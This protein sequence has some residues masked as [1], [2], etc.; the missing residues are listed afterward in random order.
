MEAIPAQRTPFVEVSAPGKLIISGEHSVVYGKNALCAALDLRCRCTGFTGGAPTGSI[1]FNL[2]N[3]SQSITVDIAALKEALLGKDDIE[4][5]SDFL[6]SLNMGGCE[7][8][9]YN[10]KILKAFRAARHRLQE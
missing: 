7:A 5:Y 10:Y 1:C 8:T 6:K 2:K 9:L 4:N 3:L